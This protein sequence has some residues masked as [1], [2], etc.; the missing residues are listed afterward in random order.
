MASSKI[1]LMQWHGYSSFG[2]DQYQPQWIQAISVEG[3]AKSQT[4]PFNALSH[5]PETG[6]WF[7][8]AIQQTEATLDHL[9]GG[10][11]VL[12][13]VKERGADFLHGTS[14]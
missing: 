9:E 8:P 12:T 13:D 7:S 5:R 3:R 10:F 2:L 4:H 1:S 14:G 11:L 6:Y